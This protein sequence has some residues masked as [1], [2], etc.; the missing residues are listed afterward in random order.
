MKWSEYKQQTK[1]IPNI[2]EE[3]W[4]EQFLLNMICPNCAI[5]NDM[6]ITITKIS[7]KIECSRKECEKVLFYRRINLGVL[8]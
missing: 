4:S 3:V 5:I 8:E 6:L 1:A 2:L 7:I